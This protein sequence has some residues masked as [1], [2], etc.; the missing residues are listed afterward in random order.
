MDFVLFGGE[1]HRWALKLSQF[2]FIWPLYT[3]CFPTVKAPV[4]RTHEC[5]A[6]KLFEPSRGLRIAKQLGKGALW[7][8]CVTP[9]NPWM[10]VMRPIIHSICSV[11]AESPHCSSTIGPWGVFNPNALRGGSRLF[12]DIMHRT[13][14]SN[15]SPPARCTDCS[16]SKIADCKGVGTDAW[17]VI[18]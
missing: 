8:F 12:C 15:E 2:R 5:K 14:T 6:I 10:F 17:W 18:G 3:I 11:S 4:Y 13:N 16:V 9:G 1:I 7:A